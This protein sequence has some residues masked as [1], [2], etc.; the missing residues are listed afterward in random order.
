MDATY[1]FHSR[2]RYSEVDSKGFL[3]LQSLLDYFQDS[4]IFHSEDRGLS[5]SYLN[6]QH[7][8]WVLSSWQIIVDRYPKLGENITIETTPY[9]MKGFLGFRNFVLFDE[10]GQRIACANSIWS[11]LDTDAQ[12]PCAV[13]SYMVERYGI[14]S[15]LDMPYAPRKIQMPKELIEKESIQIKEWHLDTNHHV[16]NG[17]FVRMGLDLL[18]ENTCIKQL[19]AE[20]KK[21]ALLSDI[22]IPYIGTNTPDDS[23]QCYCVSLQDSQHDVYVNMEFM[24]INS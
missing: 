1:R 12:K 18:P 17:Q 9:D 21:Q 13:P 3:T 8:C 22:V 10:Q 14:G 6:Q 2:I 4:S 7:V 24:T 15:K 23:T 20:Y 19:R 5:V 16:N 11:L